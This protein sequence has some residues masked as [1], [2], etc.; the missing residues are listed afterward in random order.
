MTKTANDIIQI[1]R[2]VTGRVDA[3]DPQFTD[4]IILQYINDFYLLEMGQQLRLKEQ[5]TWWD[6]TID[7]TTPDPF[8]VDLQ[9]PFQATPGTQFT[10][11]GPLIYV[12]GFPTWWYESPEEFYYKWPQTQLYQ[13]TRPTDVLYYNQQLVF[14]A[15]PN[16]AY[17]VRI[18]AYQVEL[19]M[20]VDG[21]IS[22]DYLWRY[23]AYGAALDIFN[24]YGEQ[25]MAQ[26]IEPK[27]IDY[28]AKVYARTYQQQMSQRATPRF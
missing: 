5:R 14:R 7:P 2:N 27:F 22:H 21:K 26:R 10:T 15:P 19:E 24:D 18:E 8:P 16:E 9:N 17:S 12:N 3:S 28:K 25:D 6:F 4:T 23:V 20:P 13:P 1:V 11:I